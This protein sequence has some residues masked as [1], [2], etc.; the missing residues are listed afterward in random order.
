MHRPCYVESLRTGATAEI[1]MERV[2][3]NFLTGCDV[4]ARRQLWRLGGR[5]RKKGRREDGTSKECRR[6]VLEADDSC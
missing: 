6:L 3:R 4:S 1:R 5:P 2:E